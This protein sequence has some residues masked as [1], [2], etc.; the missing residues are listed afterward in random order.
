MK[1]LTVFLTCLSILFFGCSLFQPKCPRLSVRVI[2]NTEIEI[3][4]G[5]FTFGV[6]RIYD[7]PFGFTRNAML[8]P[9]SAAKIIGFRPIPYQDPRGGHWFYLTPVP[10]V[11]RIRFSS[12]PRYI[13]IDEFNL[14]LTRLMEIKVAESERGEEWTGYGDVFVYPDDHLQ[15][16]GG[17]EYGQ[18]LFGPTRKFPP[19]PPDCR[20]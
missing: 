17:I 5:K 8:E 12:A 18:P 2:S 10:G 13:K 9:D 19:D 15:A 6:F 16:G 14:A 1:A 4:T 20:R 3:E 7:E 11:A